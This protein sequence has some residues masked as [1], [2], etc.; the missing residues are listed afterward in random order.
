[1][2]KFVLFQLKS[3][4]DASRV[5]YICA[6]A[7]TSRICSSIRDALVR[8]YPLMNMQGLFYIEGKAAAT[9]SFT[10]AWLL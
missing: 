8:I 4:A 7:S 9:G 2:K 3:F 1:M 10:T 5:Q 6:H